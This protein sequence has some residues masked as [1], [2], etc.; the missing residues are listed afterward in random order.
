MIEIN[1]VAG[2]WDEDAARTEL[3]RALEALR[4]A[5]G[6]PD[7]TSVS[8]LLCDDAYIAGLNAEFRGKDRATNVLSWPS[9]TRPVPSDVYAFDPLVIRDPEIG[10]LAFAYE[11]VLA[12]AEA[13]LLDWRDHFLH[14]SLHGMLHLL[15]FDHE[16]E[17]EAAVMEGLEIKT[18]ETLGK[19]N[20]YID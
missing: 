3:A 14:L 5:L 1:L 15:G 20:P 7:E 11:T 10:D 4:V 13:A 9:E 19:H 16:D 8:V 12:E 2:A 17:A 18:L 6:L